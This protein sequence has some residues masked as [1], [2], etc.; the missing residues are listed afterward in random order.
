MDGDERLGKRPLPLA[1]ADDEVGAAG[2]Q[3]RPVVLGE[4]GQGLVEA[5][6]LEVRA[7]AHASTPCAAAHTRSGVIGS[8]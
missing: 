3:R 2:D 5:R 8:W 7:R 1:R 6:G 4:Q